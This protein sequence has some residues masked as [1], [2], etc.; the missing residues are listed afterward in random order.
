MWQSAE[1]Q[2]NEARQQ[3]KPLQDAQFRENTFFCAG[4]RDYADCSQ[5]STFTTDKMPVKAYSKLLSHV[6][7]LHGDILT[8]FHT[9]TIR[10][11]GITDMIC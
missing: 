11:D 3:Y 2:M 9:V 8:T 4:P 1:K 7:G 5:S 6:F 10:Q